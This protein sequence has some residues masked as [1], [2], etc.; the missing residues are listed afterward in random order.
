[1]GKDAVLVSSCLLGHRTRY[2]GADALC[3]ELIDELQGHEIIAFCPELLGGLP[4]PRPRAEIAGGTAG[5][6]LDGEA[7]VTDENGRDVTGEFIKGA[8]K[9]LE[10]AREHS[11]STA[12]LKEKSPSCGVETVYSQ[13]RLV[14]GRGVTTELLLREGI[15]I[16]G[17]K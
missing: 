12:Y 17:V 3:E 13:G 7:K 6:V 16:R 4:T 5:K 9:T 10:L 15:D 11:I 14:K 8:Q 2:D 1:M